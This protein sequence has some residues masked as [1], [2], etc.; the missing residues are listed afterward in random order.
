MNLHPPTLLLC[1]VL[2]MA[3]SAAL[4]TVFG[5]T[6]RVYRGYAHWTT[7]QALAALGLGLH[8]VRDTHPLI[9]PLANLLV[10]QW[11]VLL[12]AGLRRFYQRN[13]MPLPAAFD[14]MLLVGGYLLWLTTWVAQTDLM[15]RIA[16]FSFAAAVLLLYTAALLMRLDSYATST[17]LKTLSVALFMSCAM[18]VWRM[19]H[20]VITRHNPESAINLL[21][22]G[23]VIAV[24]LSF[25][26][27]YLALLLTYE[28]T[29]HDLGES[30]RLLRELANI[31][32]L[33]QVPNRRH[34]HELAA[35]VLAAPASAGAALLMFD[36]DHFKGINDR[37]GHRAGDEA[38]CDVAQSLRN[39]LRAGDV[40]GRLGGD[41]FVVLL[42]HTS[43]DDAVG[44]AS[45]IVDP[46]SGQ[47]PV[48]LGLSFGVVRVQPGESV[49]AALH[50][51]DQALYEAKRQGRSCAVVASGDN[52]N[53]VFAESMPLGLV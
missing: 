1:S 40:A 8:L 48:P 41:E 16:A 17:G 30:Q 2:A 32:M 38:L 20:S 9:L 28:R 51:A 27:V 7:A 21:L 35:R 12:L 26:M 6:Q 52:D 46:L 11:P 53:P 36:V 47:R 25:M 45:R 19:L 4:M 13:E 31:D 10:L 37:F 50:R 44:V 34:F 33:T 14:W 18:H 3:M 42:P 22:A 43:S 39:S 23:A 29:Q 24:L 5:F 15:W 49:D